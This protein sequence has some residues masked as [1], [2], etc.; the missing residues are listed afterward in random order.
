[1][2]YFI[3]LEEI[4]D[5]VYKTFDSKNYL[6]ILNEESEDFRCGANFGMVQAYVAIASQCKIYELKEQEYESE[7]D[8]K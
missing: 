3:N 2:S 6:R 4:G 5:C 7:A 8:C 1:M